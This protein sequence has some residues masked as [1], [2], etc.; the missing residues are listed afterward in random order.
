MEATGNRDEARRQYLAALETRPRLATAHFNLGNLLLREP[1]RLAEAIAST[2][3]E[4]LR[5]NPSYPEGYVNLGIALRMQGRTREAI[6]MQRAALRLNPQLVEAR[7]QL[8]LALAAKGEKDEAAAAF[9]AALERR[10]RRFGTRP[11]DPRVAPTGRETDAAVALHAA[12]PSFRRRRPRRPG[13]RTSQ[14][15]ARGCEAG[16]R[17]H[18]SPGSFIAG[19]STVF[20]RATQSA[21]PVKPLWLASIG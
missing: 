8:G 6:E 12:R 15:P 10:A 5:P 9:R 11:P 20:G 4:S 7:V 16:G 19:R 14:T 18:R 13:P 21:G 17:S 2:T 1:G 3:E